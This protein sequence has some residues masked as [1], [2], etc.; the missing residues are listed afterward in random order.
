MNGSTHE[1]AFR[2]VC[3][4]RF[5][6]NI[7]PL[8]VVPGVGDQPLFYSVWAYY[9]LQLFIIARWFAAFAVMAEGKQTTTLGWIWLA[10][11]TLVFFIMP[12]YYLLRFVDYD[13]YHEFM[14]PWWSG[15]D[16]TSRLCDGVEQFQNEVR[17]GAQWHRRGMRALGNSQSNIETIWAINARNLTFALGVNEFADLT[18]DEFV[19]TYSGLKPASA[20]SSLP[21]LGM[22]EYDGAPLAT[23]VDWT[24]LGVVSPVKYQG[25]WLLL[26]ILNH[27]LSRISERTA[28]R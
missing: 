8:R 26:D 7:L 24:T 10:V 14:W 5:L 15:R 3:G 13:T 21:R 20:W 9:S 18:K 23:S 2:V 28:V 19:A 6:V 1:S 17:Q 12:G 25:Q 11:C 22:H 16:T 4:I 27:G